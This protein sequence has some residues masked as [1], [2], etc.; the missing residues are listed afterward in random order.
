MSVEV[1]ELTRLFESGQIDPES[2]SHES[3]LL[4]AYDMLRKYDFMDAA[5][6]Y[7]QGIKSLAESVGVPEKVNITVTL[8]FLSVIAERITQSHHSDFERFLEENS[9]LLS[10]NLL[11]NWYTDD[12]LASDLARTSFVMPAKAA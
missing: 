4:V 12:Q 1:S 6:R 5:T 2:F 10:R 8:A 11:K 9:D 3:H 7:V